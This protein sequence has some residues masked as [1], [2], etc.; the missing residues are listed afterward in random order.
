[1]T[2][3]EKSQRDVIRILLLVFAKLIDVYSKAI[4]EYDCMDGRE[5][6]LGRFRQLTRPEKWKSLL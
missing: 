2:F 4:V 1:M 6:S 5:Y 3:I